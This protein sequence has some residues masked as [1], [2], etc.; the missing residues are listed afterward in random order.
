MEVIRYPQRKDW[1]KILQRPY[2]DNTA[3]LHSVQN[4]L[5]EVRKDGDEAIRKFTKGFDGIELENFEV[6]PGEIQRAEHQL[7]GD[8]KKAIQQA[9]NNI[10]RKTFCGVRK[11]LIT[12]QWLT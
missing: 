11:H 2:Q 6:I 5:E 7:P 1:K 3:V 8:L 12:K 10:E 4:I 9:K